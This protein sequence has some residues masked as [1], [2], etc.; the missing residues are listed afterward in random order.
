M[1]LFLLKIKFSFYLYNIYTLYIHF[2][3]KFNGSVYKVFNILSVLYFNFNPFSY[4]PYLYIIE[5]NELAFG[6]ILTQ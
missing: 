6:S 1:T 4:I 2:T 5:L 3:I